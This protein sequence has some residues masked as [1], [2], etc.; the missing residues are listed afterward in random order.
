MAGEGRSAKD[1]RTWGGTVVAAKTLVGL[2]AH[3]TKREADHNVIV[4][5]DAAAEAL[6][7]TRTVCRNCYVH[8]QV[9]ESYLD[10]SLDQAWRSSRTAPRMS[11]AEKAVLKVL[12]PGS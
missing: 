11:R 5:I 1:F 12:D 7:N 9:A 6:G 4:A 2:G 3:T 10:G 8:P